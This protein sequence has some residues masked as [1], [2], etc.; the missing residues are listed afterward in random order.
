MTESKVVLF[1]QRIVS[2]VLR[3]FNQEQQEKNSY[4]KR[5]ALQNGQALEK[6]IL[7]LEKENH[8]LKTEKDELENENRDLKSALDEL[9]TQRDRGVTYLWPEEKSKEPLH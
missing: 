2:C 4:W 8:D 7:Q 6:R 3:Q 9:R 5:V 1:F